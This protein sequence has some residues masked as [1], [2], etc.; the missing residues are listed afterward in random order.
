MRVDILDMVANAA[1][2]VFVTDR[3]LNIV[4]YNKAAE[5][6]LGFPAEE[7]LGRYCYD[8]IRGRDSSGNLL[9]HRSCYVV[10]GSREGK[11]I[12]T[13]DLVTRMKAGKEIWLNM[14]TFVTRSPHEELSAVI[15]IFR[16]I[17]GR[18]QIERLI[19][20]LNA[21]FVQA[22]EP[23]TVK[24]AVEAKPLTARELEVLRL[25]ASGATTKAIAQKLFISP[26]TARNHIRNILAK[27]G[28]HTRLEAVI[29]AFRRSLL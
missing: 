1:D 11:G 8:V 4:I 17:T 3:N 10:V 23:R 29:L 20:A 6:L 19:E 16:D 7:V 21:K 2:G 5:K 18:R 9:C 12:P 27:L 28:V 22:P 13:C 26:F 14:S 15:H 24:A 25:L